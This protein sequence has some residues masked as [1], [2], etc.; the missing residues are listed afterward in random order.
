MARAR[1]GASVPFLFAVAA[2]L[3]ACSPREAPAPGPP[4]PRAEPRLDFVELRPG[5]AQSPGA[6]LPLVV[7]VHGLGDRP[8]NLADLYDDIAVPCR[9]VLPR[10]PI[11]WGGG[12][13]WFDIDIPYR[14]DPGLA[15]GIAG[16]ADR[17]AAFIDDL[18]AEGGVEGKPILTGFSQGGMIAFAVAIRHPGSIAAAVPLAGALPEEAWPPGAPGGPKPKVRAFH[19]AADDLVP[20]GHARRTV[21]A[22]RAA[23]YDVSLTE[24]AGLGHTVGLRMR[25]DA[26]A[27]IGEALR[28]GR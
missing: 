10:A 21:D 8:E 18:V 14:P 2:L 27:A 26:L 5:P 20:V 24:Y 22:M 9:L 7:A 1:P 4:A 6:A 17:V 11:P 12:S 13:S 16:A 19:G 23:G 15:R 25:D 3:A 28:A